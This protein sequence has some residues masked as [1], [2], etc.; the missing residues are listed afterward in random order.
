MANSLHLVQRPGQR[1]AT[2]HAPTTITA[3]IEVLSAAG[4]RARP[5]AGATD[6]LLELERGGR[7]GVDTLVDLSTIAGLDEIN[8]EGDTLV[9]GPLVTHNQIVA[10]DLCRQAATPLAQACREIGSPQLRNRAT[11][12]G[13]VVTASPAND[14]IS[15]LLALNASVELTSPRGLRTMLIAEFITGFRTTALAP[16]E[17]VT[18]IMVPKLGPNQRAMFVK[19]GLRRAQAISV[20]NLAAA[21][22]F[23]DDGQTVSD[24]TIAVGSVGPTVMVLDTVA[25]SLRGRP[26]AEATITQAAEAVSAAVEPIDDVRATADYRRHLSGVMTARTL[27]AL[28]HGHHL[29]Q[30][31]ADPPLLAD[32]DQRVRG[33]PSLTIGDHDPITVTVNGSP[34]TGAGATSSNL[35]DWLRDRAGT[36]GVKEGCAEGECGACT[37]YLDGAAVMACLVPA[38]RAANHEVVTVEGLGSPDGL[39]PIQEAFVSEA[40]VQCG[41]CTPGL[42]MASAK[43]LEEHPD[44][45]RTQV[46]AGLAGNLCRCTGYNAVHAA[47]KA[48]STSATTTGTA[49]AG[50]TGEGVER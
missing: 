13:N 21:I 41:F 5:V 32:P 6:L 7:A 17:L 31:M 9:I 27:E 39:H 1:I 50:A 16:G 33:G 10:S 29:D 40:A 47:V 18:A 37:V 20:V 12:A 2:Y 3:A 25:E 45:T 26:L 48:A 34:V 30:W 19:L 35:L 15:A 11:V 14:T 28:A 8:D 44:P 24:A 23:D 46:A 42:V 38:A 22:T 43:L 36:S 4:E 49:G